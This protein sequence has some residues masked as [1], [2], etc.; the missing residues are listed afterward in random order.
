MLRLGVDPA[1]RA[2]SRESEAARTD[3]TDRRPDRGGHGSSRPPGTIAGG[4]PSRALPLSSLM[5]HAGIHAAGPG[6]PAAATSSEPRRLIR[7]RSRSRSAAAAATRSGRRRRTRTAPSPTLR[8]LSSQPTTA[9]STSAQGS[10]VINMVQK[11][12]DVS[13]KI[14]VSR[15]GFISGL[16][17]SIQL[18]TG[19]VDPDTDTTAPMEPV[20]ESVSA[21]DTNGIMREI[22]GQYLSQPEGS[23]R[24]E[25]TEVHG[26]HPALGFRC[27]H[28]GRAPDSVEAS[29]SGRSA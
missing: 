5:R 12:Q 19:D 23:Q 14:D 10:G 22:D 4:V 20:T 17:P 25:G 3:R 26:R 24:L 11:G 7:A 8:R 16:T 1:R 2:V 18:Y 21:A 6:T 29:T 13:P 15:N 9:R 27:S 28:E